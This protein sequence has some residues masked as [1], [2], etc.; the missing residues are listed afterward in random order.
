MQASAPPPRDYAAETAATLAARINLAPKQYAADAKF[1]PQYAALNNRNLDVTLNG[2]DGQRGL[3]DLYERDLY[4]TLSRIQSASQASQRENDISAVEKYGARA[5]NAIRAANP[6]QAAL[7]DSLTGQAQAGLDSNGALD[8]AMLRQYQQAA[9]SAQASRGLGFGNSDAF[10]EAIQV[11]MAA[12]NRR[13]Q[14]RQFAAQTAA[15]NQAA[16]GD[17][18][19]AI[20]GRQS[21]AFSAGG[22]LGGQAMG[23]AAS[24]GTMFNPESQYAADV[25]N[26]NYNGQMSVNAANAGAING[27]IGGGIGAI[28]SVAGGYFGRPQTNNFFGF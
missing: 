7:I 28:G 13:N 2:A 16:Y 23:Q 15:L 17:P 8:P 27:L 1:Q 26:T 22:S 19:A 9:R 18:F 20:I 11:G 4:P 10:N 5:T 14:Q 12:E 25:Y 3:L 6:Q 24:R 21:Q